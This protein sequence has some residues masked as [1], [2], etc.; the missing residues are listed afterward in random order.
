VN[1]DT[2]TRGSSVPVSRGHLRL[3]Q[4]DASE[5]NVLKTRPKMEARSRLLPP[6][7]LSALS[8]ERF[9]ALMLLHSLAHRPPLHWQRPV[10][11]LLDG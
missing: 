9:V 5:R 3:R 2:I 7:P 4:L 1:G 6:R 11:S 8:W 10:V